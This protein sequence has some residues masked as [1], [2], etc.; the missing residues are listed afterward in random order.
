M[1]ESTEEKAP[2]I[3][4]PATLLN[5]D[6]IT[7]V[8]CHFLQALGWSSMLLL[9]RYFDV[10]GESREDI[11]ILMA[12]ASFGGLVVRPVV[13][14]ALDYHG[15][16]ICLSLGSIFLTIGM[17][18]LSI[19]D[20][21]FTTLMIARILVGIGAG[22]LFT[23]YFAFVAQHIPESRRTEGL[24]LFGISGILFGLN[25]ITNQILDD[26]RMIQD[27]FPVLSIPIIISGLLIWRVGEAPVKTDDQSHAGSFQLI[28]LVRPELLPVWLAT[29][30]FS[31]LV[32]A[33]MAFATLCTPELAKHNPQSLWLYYALGAVGVR[34]FA[35]K[36]PDKLGTRNFVV[37]SLAAY[38]CA[39]LPLAEGETAFIT[40]LQVYWRALSRLLFPA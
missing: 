20:P 4:E 37:P 40:T 39:F 8:V 27:L 13:G 18:S 17:W 19:T 12:A 11:G 9:P 6:F 10:L 33:F 23:G 2:A 1:V 26:P 5:R 15:K 22:T 24:A 32:A 7:L 36:L 25:A 28:S 21:S 35:A 3:V 14:W 30:I 16:R 38:C 29:L 34:V 31:T